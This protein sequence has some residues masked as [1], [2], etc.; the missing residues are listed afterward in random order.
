M[1]EYVAARRQTLRSL[2]VVSLAALLG[3]AACSIDT[4][5]MRLPPDITYPEEEYAKL[6]EPAA[7]ELWQPELPLGFYLGMSV[8]QAARQQLELTRAGH[9]HVGV[10]GPPA[11]P[12]YTFVSADSTRY[13]GQLGFEFVEEKLAKLTVT[14]YRAACA[15]AQIRNVLDARYGSTNRRHVPTFYLRKLANGQLSDNGPAGD[16]HH[17]WLYGGREVDLFC[18]RLQPRIE[19]SGIRLLARQRYVD[20]VRASHRLA[21]PW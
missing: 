4:T 1:H 7:T 2:Y 3:L 9:I 14:L 11:T 15:D 8:K 13:E 21:W 5:G 19:Y 16:W 10:V 20:S 6:H 12:S 18:Y 17:L